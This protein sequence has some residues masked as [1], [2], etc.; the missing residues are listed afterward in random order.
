MRMMMMICYDDYIM[1]KDYHNLLLPCLML[2]I[3]MMMIMMIFFM[4]DGEYIERIEKELKIKEYFEQKLSNEGMYLFTL[5][6]SILIIITIL[7]AI[8][9]F[10]T[11][12]YVDCYNQYH[13]S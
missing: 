7:I 8:I 5:L 13:N 10:S 1:I 6:F 12:H 9:I 3:L 11:Y 4:N 2:S